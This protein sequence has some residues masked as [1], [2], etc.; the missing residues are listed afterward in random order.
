MNQ[1]L[2]SQIRISVSSIVPIIIIVFLLSIIAVPVDTGSMMLFLSGSLLLIVGMA[3]FD[4]GA[5]MAMTRIGDGIGIELA[6]SGKE[7]LIL[8]ITF[9]MGFV[10]TVAEP[11][12]QVLAQQ[13]PAIPDKVLIY[14][15][16]VGVGLFLSFAVLRIIR[17]IPLS[18][19]LMVVYGILIVLSLFVPK[20]FIG[21]AFDS[22]GV[23]TGPVTVPF[24]MSFGV[25]LSTMRLDRESGNDSFGLISLASAGP[26]IAVMILGMV[27]ES[28]NAEVSGASSAMVHTMNDVFR[29]FAD[30]IG[31]YLLEVGITVLPL[32]GMYLIFQL[33]T[34]RYR[35]TER[36][37]IL[38]GFGYTWIGL[39]LFLCGVNAGFAPLGREI[40]YQLGLLEHSWI[41]I[42]LGMVM[43]YYIVQAEPAIQTLNHQVSSVTNG[44][45]PQ[46]DMNRALSI[47]VS[48]S[49]GLAMSRILFHINL[50]YLVIPGYAIALI[51]THFVPKMFV[52]IAFDS[53]GVASGPMTSTFLL[54]MCIGACEA[55]GGNIMTD[56]FGLVSL[57][58][59]TP[60]I[61][62]QLMGLKFKA[63]TRQAESCVLCAED[64]DVI[65]DLSEEDPG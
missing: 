11:D 7:W 21:V 30:D 43:G 33:F 24:I 32:I 47:G 36:F 62:V 60:L 15:V 31:H 14:T 25:G 59:L 54:P 4:I 13:V 38:I 12:L 57:V 52:G 40:G 63:K 27:Y 23:T 28:G 19:V 51:L 58:A 65:I 10:V 48:V 61:A 29:V 1:K 8:F 20:E 56:A 55:S 46:K 50:M 35:K 49:V 16:A 6:G 2:R 17:R 45:V 18:I 41:L 64:D 53:G 22:G 3:L 34:K 44:A 9:A 26:I 5:E 42:P 37:R 39:A